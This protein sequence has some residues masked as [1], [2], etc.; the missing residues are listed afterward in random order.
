MANHPGC[1]KLHWKNDVAAVPSQ[2]CPSDAASMVA[3]AGIV[4]YT[5]MSLSHVVQ[6][7]NLYTV[8]EMYVIPRVGNASGH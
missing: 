5:A 2:R 3:Y 6:S 4:P 8:L 1:A 7:L